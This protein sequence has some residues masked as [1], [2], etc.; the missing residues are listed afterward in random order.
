MKLNWVY[1]IS[2]ASFLL[3]SEI[4]E[5]EYLHHFIENNPKLKHPSN[6]PK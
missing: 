6:K 5:L 1:F 4:Y 3:K 2:M